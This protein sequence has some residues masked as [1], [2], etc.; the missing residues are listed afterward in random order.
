MSNKVYFASDFHLGI[1]AE[2]TSVEREKLVVS[3]LE[4]IQDDIA[5]LYLVGDLFD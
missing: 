4:Q 3:W 2:K 5:Q 1:D